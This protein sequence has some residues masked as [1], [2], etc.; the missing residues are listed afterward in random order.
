[1]E[2]A[3]TFLHGNYSDDSEG[4]SYGQLVIGSFITTM[5]LLRHHI[6]CRIF[7]WN[8]KSPRWL[9]PDLESY[10]FWLFPKL[11]S[12]LKGKRFQTVSEVQ[13]NTVGQLMVIGRTG[14]GPKVPTL[15]GT[16]SVIVL[17]APFLVCCI[18]FSKCLYFTYYMAGYLLDRP[19]IFDVEQIFKHKSTSY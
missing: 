6:S 15:K 16:E 4:R 18:F 10:D 7:W 13:E 2:E 14:W 5:H 3:W 1:M 8:I 11:K 9:C 19:H 12:P 17:C